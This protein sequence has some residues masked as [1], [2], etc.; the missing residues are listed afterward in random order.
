MA[1]NLTKHK[2][3]LLAAWK[4]VLDDKSMTDW[5]LFGYDGQSNDLK[6]ISKGAGGVEEL[7]ED[8]N[9]G[10][11]MYAFCKVMD[12]KTS[13]PKCVLINWQGE[14]A[15]HARK[16]TCANHVHEVTNFFKGVHVTLNARNEEEVD[17]Q[18]VIDKVAKSTGSAYSFKDRGDLEK[19]SG[20]VG[21][22]YK[23]VIPKQEINTRERD[24]FWEKEEQE[25]KQR[26]AEEKNRKEEERTR[27]ESERKQRES[28]P[29]ASGSGLIRVSLTTCFVNRGER[30]NQGKPVVKDVVSRGSII[31]LVGPNLRHEGHGDRLYMS[32]NQRD[33]PVTKFIRNYFRN[34]TEEGVKTFPARI[35]EEVS[36]KV[37]VQI[38]GFNLGVWSGSRHQ[39]ELFCKEIR[40]FLLDAYGKYGLGAGSVAVLQLLGMDGV[41]E[42]FEQ[43]DSSGYGYTAH[44]PDALKEAAVRERRIKERT[45]SISQ[46][47]EAE[48]SAEERTKEVTPADQEKEDWEREERE[49]RGRSEILRKERS[50]EAQN[51]ISKRTFNARAVFEQNTSAGQLNS[52]RRSSLNPDH[53]PVV[54]Y[55]PTSQNAAARKASLPSWPPADTRPEQVTTPLRDDRSDVSTKVTVEEESH[56]PLNNVEESY[57]PLNNVQQQQNT[58]I[59]PVSNQKI[60]EIDRYREHLNSED[61][62]DWSS[63]AE[64][65]QPIILEAKQPAR[66]TTQPQTI[67]EATQPIIREAL[68]V[69]QCIEEEELLSYSNGQDDLADSTEITFDPGDVITHIDQIDEGWW[70]GLGPDGTYGL[71]PANYVELLN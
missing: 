30:D 4:D 68:Q 31:G 44:N 51:L 33:D 57:L 55:S 62:Q 27:I 28:H 24:K 38:V 5:A 54:N 17:P 8:L 70:Q 39:N 42:Y 71:F 2:D 15:P 43:G 56:L 34:G 7:T 3:S 20:P 49:R 60:A 25:E 36:R 6:F 19:E 45:A 63:D 11:I 66:D 52:L 69:A 35:S 21:T 67:R 1:I 18:I 53:E 23:R 37:H 22:V 64:V 14:G 61:E 47:R 46:L 10:K 48:K 13:L 16:G 9:S 29:D 40:E 50:K 26:Q 12:P 32:P 59:S 65:S 58:V 41:M